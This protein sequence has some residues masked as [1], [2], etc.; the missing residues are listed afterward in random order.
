MKCESAF[1]PSV[2]APGALLPETAIRCLEISSHSPETP[3]SPPV[4]SP[5][6]PEIR[7]TAPEIHTPPPETTMRGLE[8]ASFGLEIAPQ[9]LEILTHD[10]EI[11]TLFS[12]IS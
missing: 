8:I 5:P 12:V 11:D 9:G 10:L 3:V 1:H 4:N 2:Y 7:I 6:F